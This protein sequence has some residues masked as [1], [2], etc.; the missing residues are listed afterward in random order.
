MAGRGDGM[1]DNLI[2]DEK[3]C[4]KCISNYYNTGVICRKCDINNIPIERVNL[5]D[6]PKKKGGMQQ[7]PRG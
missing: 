2:Y 5:F 1:K 7:G 4:K 6:S 3:Y